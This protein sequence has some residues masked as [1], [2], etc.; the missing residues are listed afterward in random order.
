MLFV[1]SWNDF[2]PAPAHPARRE[3]PHASAHAEVHAGDPTRGTDMGAMMLANAL[4]VLP[5]L[6]AF[7]TASKYFM[8]GLTAGAIKE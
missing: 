5:L 2:H 7:L 8:S 4:A 6:V 1:N 3:A